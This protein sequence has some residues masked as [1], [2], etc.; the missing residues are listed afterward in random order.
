MKRKKLS[1]TE[2][3]IEAR[4]LSK[5]NLVVAEWALQ[6]IDKK[7]WELLKTYSHRFPQLRVEERYELTHRIAEILFRS[8]ICQLKK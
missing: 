3:E 2:K 7:D 5:D 1:P 6:S 8:S 4:G